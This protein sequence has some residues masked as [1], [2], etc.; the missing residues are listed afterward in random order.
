[1]KVVLEEQ[2]SVLYFFIEDGNFFVIDNDHDD[3][4]FHT[5]SFIVECMYKCNSF[6][7]RQFD[8]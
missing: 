6:M 1:M 3:G 2:Y 7:T 5:R 4:S 8:Y